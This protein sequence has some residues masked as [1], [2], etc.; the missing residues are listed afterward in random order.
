MRKTNQIDFLRKP[1]LN[2]G[3]LNRE[4][5]LR[6]WIPK[7]NKRGGGLTSS[8]QIKSNCFRIESLAW[9]MTLLLFLLLP[10]TTTT[11]PTIHYRE[12]VN[13]T[14]HFLRTHSFPWKSIIK[15][16]NWDLRK[17]LMINLNG[18]KHDGTLL[19]YENLYRCRY[20]EYLIKGEL[21]LRNHFTD[22]N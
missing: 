8:W 21:N 7:E 2:G 4:N 22:F 12:D 9:G 3:S 19:K 10:T 16:V 20:Y 11:T 14:V 17:E 1:K 15:V 13:K 18:L 6:E 5:H